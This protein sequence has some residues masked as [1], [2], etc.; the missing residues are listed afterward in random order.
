MGGTGSAGITAASDLPSWSGNFPP[1]ITGGC[2][3]VPT[4]NAFLPETVGGPKLRAGRGVTGTPTA[5]A[6]VRGAGEGAVVATLA[7]EDLGVG[8]PAGRLQPE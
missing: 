6:G 2:Y 5:G 4:A 3:A 1:I 7:V 8:V